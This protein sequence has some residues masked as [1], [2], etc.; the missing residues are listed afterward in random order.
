MKKTYLKLS[1]D[2][3]W[4]LQLESKKNKEPLDCFIRRICEY[5]RNREI[6]KENDKKN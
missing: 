2:L 6:K 1:Y 3:I 5:W 4:E